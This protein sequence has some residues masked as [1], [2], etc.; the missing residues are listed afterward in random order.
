M[1]NLLDVETYR[2]LSRRPRLIR[3]ETSEGA[4]VVIDEVQLL[5]EV[6]LLIEEKKVRF[7]FTGSS[8]RKLRRNGVNLLGG[9][10]S[11]KTLRP[12]VK[13]EIGKQFDLTQALTR[14]LLPA[15]YTSS[16]YKSDLKDYVDIYTARQ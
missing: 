8:A 5:N 3:E 16:H 14:G 12:L 1:Y 15:I 11:W 13:L 6:H 7:L 10:A 9:R 4:L 2:S